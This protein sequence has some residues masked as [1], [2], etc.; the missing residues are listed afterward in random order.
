MKTLSMLFLL[1]I[2]QTAVAFGADFKTEIHDLNGEVIM[3]C[4]KID[5]GPPVSCA[6][7]V[8]LTLGR[9]LAGAFNTAD[10][11]APPAEM[12]RRGILAQKVYG[13]DE[14]SLDA[15]DTKLA[16]ELVAKRG[17]PP[18]VIYQVIKLLDPASVKD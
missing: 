10:Q 6:K 4:A 17:W 14:L 9:V 12:V 18:A 7:Q 8:P 5:T 1:L 13:A 16:K 3:D 15:E 2:C 11:A